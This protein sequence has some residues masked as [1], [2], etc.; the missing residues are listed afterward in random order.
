M[1]LK[2]SP[3]ELSNQKPFGDSDCYIELMGGCLRFVLRF[4]AMEPRLEDDPLS[5][6]IERVNNFTVLCMRQNVAGVEVML[7]DDGLW[8]VLIAVSGFAEDLKIYFKKEKE[9]RWMYGEIEKWLT[10]QPQP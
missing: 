1:K 6:M 7:T 9:A 4:K 10:L 3:C 8:R 2:F 5:G